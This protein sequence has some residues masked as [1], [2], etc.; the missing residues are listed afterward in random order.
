MKL[1]NQECEMAKLVESTLT[2]RPADSH[3]LPSCCLPACLCPD[4]RLG[5]SQRCWYLGLF[6]FVS[7][8]VSWPY[9]V[10]SSLNPMILQLTLA[11]QLPWH[12]ETARV[13]TS[14][15]VSLLDS[16]AVAHAPW[17]YNPRAGS[18]ALR[19]GRRI[20]SLGQWRPGCLL[21]YST[22]VVVKTIGIRSRIRS[23]WNT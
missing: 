7:R 10:I 3:K 5:F 8:E 18:S 15:S 6:C 20:W 21:C 4:P 23:C 12:L 17:S 1:S 14:G 2:A 22:H 19:A 9:T 16:N 13:V 11:Y